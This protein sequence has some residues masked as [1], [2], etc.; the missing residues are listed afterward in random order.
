MRIFGEKLPFGSF[1]KL[2]FQFTVIISAAASFR[3]SCRRKIRDEFQWINKGDFRAGLPGT[4]NL[5][6]I[7]SNYWIRVILQ[8]YSFRF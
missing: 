4:I 2:L 5:E 6:T 3:S 8:K 7:F 1:I